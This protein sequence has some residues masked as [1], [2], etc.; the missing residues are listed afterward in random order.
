MAEPPDLIDAHG[1]NYPVDTILGYIRQVQITVQ[2]QINDLKVLL[3][4]RHDT[5]VKAVEIA[6]IAQRVSIES[7]LASVIRLNEAIQK[8]SDKAIEKAE[9][10]T[11]RR[12][13]STNEF[14]AQLTDQA[15][16]FITRHE[17]ITMVDALSKT[18]NTDVIN[19]TDHLNALELRLTSRLD[20]HQGE[21]SGETSQL[22]LRR[23]AMA[24]TISI[25]SLLLMF[26]SVSFA[27][28]FN[29]G[30]HF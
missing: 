18:I 20:L 14:R 17:V 9:I 8:S 13:A 22:V 4:E 7:A 26:V 21:T 2:Q 11:E 12:F 19:L 23:A 10:A 29:K 16:T 28:F 24:Q 27:L 5:Q 15:A 25:I 6:F 3:N 1:A 30:V